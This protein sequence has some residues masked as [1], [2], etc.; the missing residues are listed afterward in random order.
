MDEV[1]L[2]IQQ[3]LTPESWLGKGRIR[4]EKDSV[5]LD[6][7]VLNF[8]SKNVDR[9]VLLHKLSHSRIGCIFKYNFK[10]YVVPKF[11]VIL[12]FIFFQLLFKFMV[13]CVSIRI[14]YLREH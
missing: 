13:I 8:F 11:N 6:G 10:F 1:V 4:T 2:E 7:S 12:V 5:P 3:K 9:K 14:D